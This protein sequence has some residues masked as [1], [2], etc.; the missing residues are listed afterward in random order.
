LRL[1]KRTEEYVVDTETEAIGL[2]EYFRK[3]AEENGY[4]IGKS[5]YVRKEKKAKGEVIAEVFVY[6]VTKIIG[7]IWDE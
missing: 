6:T 3:D 7:G 4:I 2:T 5:G 1:I